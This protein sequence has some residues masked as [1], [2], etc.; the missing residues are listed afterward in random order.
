MTKEEKAIKYLQTLN[1]GL[2]KGRLID[3][4]TGDNAERDEIFNTAIAALE[5]LDKVGSLYEKVLLQRVEDLSERLKADKEET[6]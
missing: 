3:T 5:F 2:Q 6:K 4:L 1:E